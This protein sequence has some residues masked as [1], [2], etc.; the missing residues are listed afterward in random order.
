MQ[1]ISSSKRQLW[2]LLLLLI[3]AAA[4]CALLLSY[5][6]PPVLKTELTVE[7]GPQILDPSDFLTEAIDPLPTVSAGPTAEAFCVPGSYPVTLQWDRY[8][9]EATVHV[10]DTTPPTGTVT[11]VSSLGELPKPTDFLIRYDDLT[12]V[13]VSYDKAPDMAVN[14]PQE[15]RILLEDTSGNKTVL[16][17]LLILNLDL[18][19]PAIQGV[20]DFLIYQGDTIA[21]RTGVTLTDNRDLAPSLSV[22][23]SGVDLSQPGQYTVTYTA[24]DAAGN[25]SQV[26]AT[27][28]VREK[29][30]W[31]VDLDTIYAA[32]DEVLAEIIKPHMTA[33]QQ[34]KAIYNWI[35]SHCYYVNHSDKSDYFQAAYLMLTERKGD[36]FNYYSL[37]KVMF[38]RLGIPNIDVRKVKNHANDSDHYWSLVSVDGGETYYHFDTVP[39]VGDGGYFF[40]VTDK[41]LDAYSE[42]HNNCFNR[43][44]S[45]YPATPD[46]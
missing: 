2:W 18:E 29:Q 30:E 5:K 44:K 43:D 17:A 4:V 34:A 20:H 21:Y 41:Y 32:V 24:T 22:D 45:L 13:T 42:S 33:R 1:P 8:T 10:V 15:V 39:R 38:D 36:C 7:A 40:L 12:E 35:R 28:T 23:A 27:V 31:F 26:Q 3:P 6:E 46:A 14:G 11:S 25:A 16:P 37:S 9:F 19:A